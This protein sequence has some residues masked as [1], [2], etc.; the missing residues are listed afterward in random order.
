MSSK[1]ATD[2][3][4]TENIE[5]RRTHD[6]PDTN[7]PVSDEN[8]WRYKQNNENIPKPL[9]VWHVFVQMKFMSFAL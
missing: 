1:D 9:E 5:D 7:I 4:D 6:G 8:A 3:Y 2:S